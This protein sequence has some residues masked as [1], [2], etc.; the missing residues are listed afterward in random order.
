MEVLGRVHVTQ[1]CVCQHCQLQNGKQSCCSR[2]GTSVVPLGLI[3]GGAQTASGAVSLRVRGF[4]VQTGTA[5]QSQTYFLLYFGREVG[6]AKKN[7]ANAIQVRLF[8][9]FL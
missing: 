1:G 3:A 2:R 6:F 7:L 4:L 8:S 5:M 9:C